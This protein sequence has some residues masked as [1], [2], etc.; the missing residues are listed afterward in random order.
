MIHLTT[1]TL[2]CAV[3]G[4]LTAT[5]LYPERRPTEDICADWRLD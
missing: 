3:L 4:A 2:T 1:L 5:A